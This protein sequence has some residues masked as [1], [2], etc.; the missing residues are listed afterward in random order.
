MSLEKP[1]DSRWFAD[2][3]QVHAAALRAWVR[4]RYPAVVDPD[5]LVQESLTRVWRVG[6]GGTVRSP[7]A[8]LFTTASHLALDEL[9]RRKIVPFESLG[10]FD[11]ESGAI[12]CGRAHTFSKNGL[13]MSCVT[14]VAS[15]AT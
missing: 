15:C 2:E 10:D 8:L 5:N 4:S 12:V 1:A 6:Q 7:K 9:R 13:F 11:S 14:M 3:V